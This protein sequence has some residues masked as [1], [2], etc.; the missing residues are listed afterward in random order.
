LFLDFD[1]YI[2]IINKNLNTGVIFVWLIILVPDQL[3][4]G[5][6]PDEAKGKGNVYYSDTSNNHCLVAED[7]LRLKFVEFN[8]LN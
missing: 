3:W 7:F 4:G 2:K 1:K 5:V 6:F 8:H